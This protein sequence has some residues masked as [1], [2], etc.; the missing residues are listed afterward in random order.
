[1]D[2]LGSPVFGVGPFT[3]GGQTESVGVSLGHPIAMSGTRVMH[4]YFLKFV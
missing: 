2:C 1:M 4:F 3:G